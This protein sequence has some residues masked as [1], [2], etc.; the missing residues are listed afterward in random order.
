MYL[1]TVNSP[2]KEEKLS[3]ISLLG[4]SID[5]EYCEYMEDW[6]QCDIDEKKITLS[7]RCLKDKKQHTNTLIHEITHMIFEM[8]GVAYMDKNDEE[9]YVRCVENLLIPWIIDN[10]DIL[11]I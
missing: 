4:Q 11:N 5:I 2:K 8:S 10:K 9:A 6:G 3:K 1:F 7:S